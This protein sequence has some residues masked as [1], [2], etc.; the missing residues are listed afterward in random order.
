MKQQ[1]LGATVV[2]WQESGLLIGQLGA[3]LNGMY[4]L[5]EGMGMG[6]VLVLVLGVLKRGVWDQRPPAKERRE[7]REGREEDEDAIFSEG[8]FVWRYCR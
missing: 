7:R 1:L 8:G 5:A 3:L 2:L 6:M 4:G